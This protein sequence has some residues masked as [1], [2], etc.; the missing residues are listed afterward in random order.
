[1]SAFNK[2]FQKPPL[3]HHLSD[4]IEIGYTMYGPTLGVAGRISA[5]N[6]AIFIH[7]IA[8]E[9]TNSTHKTAFHFG[10]FQ[11]RPH[12]FTIGGLHGLDFKMASKF[13]VYPQN[14]HQ[15]N[16]LFSDQKGYASIKPT[17][18]EIK[19]QWSFHNE[20]IK[21]NPAHAPSGS[22]FAD[23]LKAPVTQELLGDLR[24][25]CYWRAGEYL[26]NILVNTRNPNQI[27]RVQRK[28]YVNDDEIQLLERNSS[29]IVADLCKISNV[30]YH[31][32]S[33]KITPVT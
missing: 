31:F 23:F 9:I 27:F 24:A 25:A 2:F 4:Q 20:L 22:I 8:L 11:F 19:R 28:F 14:P 10:W 18:L 16:I 3:H 21:N 33:S 1:M 12:K 15:Y 26:L 32:L 29:N 5:N 30:E 13:M 6:Q 7:D 17:L